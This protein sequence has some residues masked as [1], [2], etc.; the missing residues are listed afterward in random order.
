MPAAMLRAPPSRRS[1]RRVD[2]DSEFDLVKV[3]RLRELVRRGAYRV[4]GLSVAER[5]LSDHLLWQWAVPDGR[6]T[7]E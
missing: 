6:S 7:D 3:N 5:L 2:P 1:N 4:D